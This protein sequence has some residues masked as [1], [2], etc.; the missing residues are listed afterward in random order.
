MICGFFV[1][2]KCIEVVCGVY[3]F[4]FEDGFKNEGKF[5]MECMN[6]L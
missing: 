4:V 2:L 1:L 5:F 6:M 3:M